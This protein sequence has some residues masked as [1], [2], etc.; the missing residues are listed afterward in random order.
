MARPLIKLAQ[1]GEAIAIIISPRVTAV[2]NT[3]ESPPNQRDGHIE[4]I[5]TQG[6]LA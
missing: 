4:M 5:N 2:S 3:A 6:R 1:V